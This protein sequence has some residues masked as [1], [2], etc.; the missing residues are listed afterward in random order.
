MLEEPSLVV[1][2]LTPPGR[3][4]V[5][6]LWVDGPNAMAVVQSRFQS[7]SNVVLADAPA[8]RPLFGHFGGLRGEEVVVRVFSPEA[9]EIHCHGG[10]ASVG[11]VRSRLMQSGCRALSWEAMIGRRENDPLAAAALVALAQASTER[12]A[13]LLL[14]QCQGVLRC[15]LDDLAASI[16]CGDR[17]AAEVLL[18]T[19]LRRADV[20]EHLASP[21]RVV[22][23]GPPNA[24]KSRLMN[25][26]VGYRRAIVHRVAGTTRDVVT[27]T[28]SFD[29]WPVE[30]ADTAG[31]RETDHPIEQAGVDL[32]RQKLEQADLVV[33]VFDGSQPWTARDAALVAAYPAAIVVYNKRDLVKDPGCRSSDRPAGMW[34]SASQGDGLATLPSVL[35]ARLVPD[36]PAVGEAIPFAPS[37]RVQLQAVLAA[38]V[39]GRL[40]E[41]LASLHAGPFARRV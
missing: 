41:A 10:H 9:V 39:A 36:P 34:V 30:L 7:A 23:A 21:W 33:L 1:V 22:L 12:T 20:G 32:A 35:A 5:A 28:T 11:M 24:G 19:L 14:T 3:G 15:A 38:V 25:A 31:L 17:P 16:R 26:L 18:K 27:A 13:S 4:A 2:Q 40:P 6:T 29:G 37:Q 8:D